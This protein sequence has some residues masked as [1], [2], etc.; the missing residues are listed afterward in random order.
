MLGVHSTK[1]DNEKGLGVIYNGVLWYDVSHMMNPPL[2]LSCSCE[3]GDVCGMCYFLW[4][5]FSF[6]VSSCA[7]QVEGLIHCTH[8]FRIKIH[9]WGMILKHPLPD[10]EM[11]FLIGCSNN[12]DMTTW[13]QLGISFMAHY[14]TCEPKGQ[15]DHHVYGWG[16]Y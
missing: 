16:H 6:L 9:Q 11:V 13:W 2:F 12:K 14:Y 1:F 10:Q 7:W 5:N 3:L 4:T 8:E 15:T